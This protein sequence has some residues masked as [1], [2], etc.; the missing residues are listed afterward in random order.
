MLERKENYIMTG[1]FIKDMFMPGHCGRC[2]MAL[3][4][5]YGERTCFITESDVTDNATWIE[6]RPD[7]CP[8]REME[9]KND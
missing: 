1:V 6:D 3:L 4:N 9:V 2:P 5:H 7:D 8:M